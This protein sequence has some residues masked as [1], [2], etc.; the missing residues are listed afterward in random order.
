LLDATSLAHCIPGCERLELIG[1]DHYRAVIRVGIAAIRGTFEGEVRLSDQTPPTGY[2][3]HV[4]AKGGPGS[5]SG[6]ATI[7]LT[8]TPTGTSVTVD[9][10]ARISGPAA[11]VAQR[12]FGGIA[13][14]MMNQFF[15]CLA[16]QLSTAGRDT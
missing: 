6:E 7:R 15:G 16:G 4:T 11:G 1:P 8:E 9:G 2:R 14:S 12:L 3:M 5:V 10:D 13:D